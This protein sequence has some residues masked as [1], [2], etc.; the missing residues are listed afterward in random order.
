MGIR[1]HINKKIAYWQGVYEY[2]RQ[3]LV[4]HRAKVRQKGN[5][6]ITH[7][8]GLSLVN[9]LN[10]SERKIKHWKRM[11]RWYNKIFKGRL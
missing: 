11:L 8:V 6:I 1:N 4:I 10:Q 5:T 9:W 3:R 7:A 2:A